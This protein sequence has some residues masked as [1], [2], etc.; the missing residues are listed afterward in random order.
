MNTKDSLKSMLNERNLMPVWEESRSDRTENQSCWAAKR[1][2][3]L[4]LLCEEEYGFMPKQHD[5]LRWEVLE[6][7]TSFCAGKATLQKVL[8]TAAFGTDSFSF[9]I[10]AAIPNAPGKHPF[11]VL[12][13]FSDK[14]P[15]KYLPS[16]EICDRGYGVI[17]FWCEDVAADDAKHS[18]V[19]DEL[20][21]LLLRC[22]NLKAAAFPDAPLSPDEPALHPGNRFGKIRLWAWAASRAMDYAC[23]LDSLDAGRAAVVG[24]SRLGKTALLAGAL[25]E[26]FSCVIS[27]DSGCSGAAISRG[28]VGE[29]IQNITDVFDYWFCPNYKNYAEKE[30]TLPF[31]QHFLL[32]AI[33]PRKVYV[34]SA[35][36][37][38]WADPV[39]EFLSC[40]AA[41]EIYEKLGLKG[42]VCPDRLPE[43]GEHFHEGN[44]GYHLRKGT[45]YLSREDWNLFMDYLDQ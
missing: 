38:L 13:N 7:D 21:E 8:L 14:V 9:P 39:S 18:G 20:K 4:N 30:E 19:S 31:D 44:I 34:A 27:N 40:A 33:A 28:K 41:S 17:S 25:D 1:K 12:I 15:D 26:R 16:E 22:Y 3:I 32:A 43:A 35:A 5:S 42:L 24:H 45:H 36:E 10:Y 2:E 23:S 29:R 6:E 11:F 37:D